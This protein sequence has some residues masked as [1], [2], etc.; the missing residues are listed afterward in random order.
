MEDGDPPK[1]RTAPRA[2]HPR[3]LVCP[4]LLYLSGLMSAARHF[5]QPCPV[6]AETPLAA[7]HFFGFHDVCPW[8]P[9]NQCLAILRVDRALRRVPDGTDRAEVCLWEPDSGDMTA[10]GETHAWN[11]QQGARAQ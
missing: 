1:I 3:L 11:W 8:D 6:I 4:Y 5:S 7:A 2:V 9:T 10:I